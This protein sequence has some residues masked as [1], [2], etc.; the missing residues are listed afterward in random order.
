[1]TTEPLSHQQLVRN[2]SRTSDEDGTA[3]T[4]A[5]N[6]FQHSAFTLASK[7]LST[8]RFHTSSEPLSFT[9]AINA[10]NK[11]FRTS[12]EENSKSNHIWSY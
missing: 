5:T 12:K 4:Q 9:R 11:R 1:M 3:F 2:H 7:L 8:D 6:G 10:F